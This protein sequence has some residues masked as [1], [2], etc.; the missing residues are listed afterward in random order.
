MSN[1]SCEV[2]DSYSQ[3]DQALE[4]EWDE[5]VVATRGC[6]Y[7][8]CAWSRIWWEFYGK[9]HSLRI[10][11]FRIKGKLVGVMPI[12]IEQIRIGFIVIRIARL[13]GA[14]NP[15]RVFDLPIHDKYAE[16]AGRLL[17]KHL[18]LKNRCDFVS[19]GPIS[20]ECKA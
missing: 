3:I 6:I 14:Y 9:K 10:F 20:D 1:I 11:L 19:I 17:L 13:V 15:S 5:L 16:Y 18:T 8:T 7:L 4:K 2:I 12:Y